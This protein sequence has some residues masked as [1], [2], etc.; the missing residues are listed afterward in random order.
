MSY[1]PGLLQI[2][3]EIKISSRRAR[4]TDAVPQLRSC[5]VAPLVTNCIGV[6]SHNANTAWTGFA[7][8]SQADRFQL[9][10]WRIQSEV[11]NHLQK[12]ILQYGTGYRSFVHDHYNTYSF[13]LTHTLQ[14]L[15]TSD[16]PSTLKTASWLAKLPQDTFLII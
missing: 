13:S 10:I 6:H 9:L 7:L 15:S 4:H 11:S 14:Y 5:I 16:A 2:S 3:K 8:E 1:F 12:A